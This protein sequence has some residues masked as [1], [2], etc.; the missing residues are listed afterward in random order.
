[1]KPP[2][3]DAVERRLRLLV[4][5]EFAARG[6]YLDAESFYDGGRMETMEDE[7]LELLA[8]VAAQRGDWSRAE[9]RFVSL[10]ENGAGGE[11]R[12]RAGE[13]ASYA[14]IQATKPRA[15]P[16]P[17][18]CTAGVYWMVLLAVV[19]GAAAAVFTMWGLRM[20]E[21]PPQ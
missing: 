3:G 5:R 21:W 14:R 1:M 11:M 10:A 6:Y 7:E 17:N 12:V 19:A 2:E 15:T 13:L 9:R 16:P 4:A 18:N 8:R 20:I